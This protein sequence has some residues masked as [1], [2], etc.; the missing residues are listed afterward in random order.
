MLEF[1]VAQFLQ[2]FCGIN[3]VFSYAVT[4]FEV[5]RTGM[6]IMAMLVNVVVMK[7]KTRPRSWF[8]PSSLYTGRKG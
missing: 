5:M 6:M 4:I 8:K 3:A 2:Q 1:Q 7:K